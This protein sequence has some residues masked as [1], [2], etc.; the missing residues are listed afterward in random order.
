[1]IPALALRL[2]RVNFGVKIDALLRILVDGWSLVSCSDKA[3]IRHLE[4]SG[5]DETGVCPLAY[6]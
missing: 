4:A 6:N 2:G 5:Q 1:M 3:E